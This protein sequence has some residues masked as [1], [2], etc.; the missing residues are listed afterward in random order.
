MRKHS[1]F[2]LLLTV[3]IVVGSQPLQSVHG[4]IMTPAELLALNSPN[5]EATDDGQVRRGGDNGFV[6]ALKSP[7]K[8]LGRLFGGGK[9]ENKLQRISEKDVKKFEATAGDQLNHSRAVPP[10]NHPAS[11][12]DAEADKLKTSPVDHLG[13]GRAL[14][15]AGELNEAIEE[16]SIVASN[17]PRSGEASNLLGVAYETKG[18]RGLA[19]KSFEL[20]IQL[21]KDNPEY[22]NNLGYLLYRSREYEAATKYLKRAAKLA[23]NDA[24]IWNNL[25][26]AQC[27]RGKFDDAYQSFVRGLGEYR[28]R[29]NIA[30]RLD[31]QGSTKE[32]IK[33]LEKARVLQPNSHEA[34]VQL[35]KL[36]QIVG[37]PERAED[38]RSSLKALDA[39]AKTAALQ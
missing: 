20:A 25:G 31:A 5:G 34:L 33:H 21:E 37:K 27:E 38:A 35:M 1:L 12:T 29:L 30:S 2:V 13:R 14:L 8:A 24:R 4:T 32:A 16:L 6:R 10:P 26:L 39:S 9:K 18:Y 11:V 22:L 23:G 17:S 7:F 3:A 15:R 19:L 28:A 36:Y